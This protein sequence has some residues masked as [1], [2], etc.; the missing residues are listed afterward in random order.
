MN[1]KL[2]G[3]VFLIY[4]SLLG[5]FI[6]ATWVKCIYNVNK[7][8]GEMGDTFFIA[9]FFFAT[10]YYGLISYWTHSISK[11]PDSN[12][13]RIQLTLIFLLGICTSLW[14]IIYIYN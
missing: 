8:G 3:K 2:I 9:A 12:S 1:N 13:V 14:G 7:F 6:V 10:L 11:K 4:F 5:L